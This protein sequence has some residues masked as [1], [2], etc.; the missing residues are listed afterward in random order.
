[1]DIRTILIIAIAMTIAATPALARSPTD[2]AP[3]WTF[4]TDNLG[5]Y[6]QSDDKLIRYDTTRLREGFALSGVTA[7][8]HEILAGL[9]IP[10]AIGPPDARGAKLELVGVDDPNLRV[11]ILDSEMAVTQVS[12]IDPPEPILPPGPCVAAFPAG[13]TL[14]VIQSNARVATIDVSM[15]AD[16]GSIIPCVRVVVQGPFAIDGTM[17]SFA[18]DLRLNAQGIDD[19]NI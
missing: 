14:N 17:L 7:A 10:S 12:C 9:Y 8:G 5:D 3:R 6:A 2:S 18:G 4:G 11:T 16:D 15:R 19:P 13:H 1:M